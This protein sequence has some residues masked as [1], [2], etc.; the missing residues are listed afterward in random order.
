M[1][2]MT[3]YS[4]EKNYDKWDT[5]PDDFD[6]YLSEQD[7]IEKNKNEKDS[8]DI[9]LDDLEIEFSDDDDIDLLDEEFDK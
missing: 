9:S 5:E 2:T 3:Q 8:D 4:W 6:M 7:E 1:K